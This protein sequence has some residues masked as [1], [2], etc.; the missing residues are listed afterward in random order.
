[1]SKAQKPK[2]P[3]VPVQAKKPPVAAKNP[4]DNVLY[5]ALWYG[6]L[7]FLAVLFI[8][9]MGTDGPK[10]KDKKSKASVADWLSGYFQE[11]YEKEMLGKPFFVD[12]KKY[13]DEK[14]Y[15]LFGKVNLDDCFSGKDNF[16]F[17]ERMTS[18]YFG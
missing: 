10:K 17:G 12:L 9:Q 2:K 14:E 3:V 16:V 1:M 15:S 4:Q 11:N 13:K 6:A 18:S 5:K 8:K 7:I